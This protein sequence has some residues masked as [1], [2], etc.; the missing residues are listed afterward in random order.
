MHIVYSQNGDCRSG[1]NT[2]L[3]R[4]S[5]QV[6]HMIYQTLLQLRPAKAKTGKAVGLGHIPY[7]L[8][9]AS[10]I[11]GQSVLAQL[12][13]RAMQERPH[14]FAWR[15]GLIWVDPP[16]KPLL[17]LSPYNSGALLC[18]EHKANH[19]AVAIR[20]ALAPTLQQLVKGNQ[21]GGI[22]GGGTEYPMFIARVF[23]KK[24]SAMT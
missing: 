15:G 11:Q 7:E 6:A 16:R 19:L 18:V 5:Q 8:Y 10:G 22:G 24:K 17:P 23:L 20:R 13:H 21:S 9:I 3:I 2:M 14:F 1:C 4:S 12:L